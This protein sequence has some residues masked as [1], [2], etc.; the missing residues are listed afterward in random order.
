MKGESGALPNIRESHQISG[1]QTEADRRANTF[2]RVVFYKVMYLGVRRKQSQPQSK[3]SNLCGGSVDAST[4]A[5][6]P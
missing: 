1:L 2:R 5:I 4:S 6:S 3:D